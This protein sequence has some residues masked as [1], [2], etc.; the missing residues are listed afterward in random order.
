M[1]S[2]LTTGQALVAAVLAGLA[3][4]S[5]ALAQ[6]GPTGPSATTIKTID[7]SGDAAALGGQWKGF[8]QLGYHLDP[9][10]RLELQGGYRDQATGDGSGLDPTGGDD[11]LGRALGLGGTCEI[12]WAASPCAQADGSNQVYAYSGKLIFD[13]APDRRWFDPFVGFGAKFVPNASPQLQILGFGP[14]YAPFAY[15]AIAGIAFKPF[16]PLHMDITYR[17]TG[18]GGL[19]QRIAPGPG[20]AGRYEDQTVAIGVRYLFA[21]PPTPPPSLASAPIQTSRSGRID[22]MTLGT[23]LRPFRLLLALAA[24]VL[25]LVTG[26]SGQSDADSDLFR[27]LLLV[28]AARHGARPGRGRLGGGLH[29]RPH[30][31][32]RL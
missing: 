13:V 7:P 24:A 18:A 14:G 20:S 23:T 3:V 12:L 4:A 9:H 19:M 15:Q 1:T 27:R 8:A 25:V 30:R 26:S 28:D 10:W 11:A 2:H 29:W 32:S 5:G 16:G 6:S 31:S 17:W 21:A 22:Q